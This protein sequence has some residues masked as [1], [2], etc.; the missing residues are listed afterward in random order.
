MNHLTDLLTNLQ[1]GFSLLMGVGPMVT[2]AAGVIFGILVGA[3]PGLSPA[4]GVA[5]LVPFTYGMPAELAIILLVS[6][7]LAADYGGSIT[8]VTINA[9]GTPSAAATALDGYQL[10]L[11]GKPGYG[12]GVSLVASTVGGLIG[13]VVL[14][15]FSIPLARLA[16]KCHPAEYFAIAVFGLTCVSAF[17]RGNAAK[18]FVATLFG[19]LLETIGIDFI[20]GVRR[21]T[22]GIEQ[23]EYGI[24]LVPALIGLFALSEVFLQIE[25]GSLDTPVAAVSQ[26]AWPSWVEYWRLRS[27]IIVSSL[28]GTIIGVFPGA[29]ATIASFIAYDTARRMSRQPERFGQGS[30]EGVAASEAANSSSVGGALVPLLTLGIP[31]SASTAVLIGALMIHKVDPNP[32]LVSTQPDLVYGLFASLFVA[33]AMLLLFGLFGSRLWVRVTAIPKPWLFPL[34]VAVSVIGSYAVQNAYIDVASCLVFGLIGWAMRRAGFPVA[35]V[36]LGIVLGGIAEKSFRQAVLMGGYDVFVTRPA[37]LAILLVATLSFALPL[38]RA[39]R[40]RVKASSPRA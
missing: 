11:Q 29:G 37:S 19:L 33:N 21:F 36:V 39:A 2:I 16:V 1:H 34:I 26:T 4:M 24:S 7:Y 28:V 38:W 20:S 40:S 3:M 12:L 10:T 14:I 18:A 30:L 9:P 13:T 8:A 25:Q 15:L 32:R 17:G 31:G 23:L 5:L 6:V 27:T 35:P 22:F